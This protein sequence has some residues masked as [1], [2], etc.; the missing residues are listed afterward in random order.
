MSNTY[1]PLSRSLSDDTNS[2]RNTTMSKQSSSTTRSGIAG[3]NVS[4]PSE[5]FFPLAKYVF[6]HPELQ[7]MASIQRG[8]DCLMKLLDKD[9]STRDFF[10]RTDLTGQPVPALL[11]SV[12][13]AG[14]RFRTTTRYTHGDTLLGMDYILMETDDDGSL[15]SGGM[16]CRFSASTR[17]G[18]TVYS[19]PVGVECDEG[20]WQKSRE[21]ASYYKKVDD[22]L[23]P[24]QST[25]ATGHFKVLSRLRN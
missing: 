1:I 12:R 10:A 11:D 14:K 21:M 15:Q 22:Q 6:E 13:E 5:I 2:T 20:Y 7:N 4:K 3:S 24:G 16:G 17:D 23:N 8:V 18:Q 9:P 19:D 25:P